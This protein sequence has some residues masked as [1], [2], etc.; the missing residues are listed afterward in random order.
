MILIFKIKTNIF[1][2]QKFKYFKVFDFDTGFK[3]EEKKKK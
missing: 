1:K 2:L 3:K